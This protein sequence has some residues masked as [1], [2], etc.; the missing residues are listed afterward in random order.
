MERKIGWKS[1]CYDEIELVYEKAEKKESIGAILAEIEEMALREA[2]ENCGLLNING[3]RIT[4][5]MFKAMTN[6]EKEQVMYNLAGI[7]LESLYFTNDSPIITI[8]LSAYIQSV[9]GCTMF[10]ILNRLEKLDGAFNVFHPEATLE[11]IVPLG[12]KKGLSKC[13]ML[14]SALYTWLSITEKSSNVMSAKPEAS[15]ANNSPADT[16]VV[17]EYTSPTKSDINGSKNEIKPSNAENKTASP[18]STKKQS[19][20]KIA[21]IIGIIV[22]LCLIRILI[23]W[24]PDLTS[25]NDNLNSSDIAPTETVS[26]NNSLPTLE[27][28]QELEEKYNKEASQQKPTDSSGIYIEFDASQKDKT[29]IVL[30]AGN[31]V[32]MAGSSKGSNW[33]YTTDV[34]EILDYLEKAKALGAE[35]VVYLLDSTSGALEG[36]AYPIDDVMEGYKNGT[37]NFNNAQEDFD[38]Q[39]KK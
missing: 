7:G 20:L 9:L 8:R 23:F 11:I 29:P 22:I 37:W 26:K 15:T 27:E 39:F 19:Y 12:A 1:Y 18:N 33:S 16:N 17:V 36:P 32:F 31:I 35:K 34:N 24:V 28:I 5:E 38:K 25:D 6:S 3:Q 4:R 10:S 14:I 21:M 13:E 30:E 2:E